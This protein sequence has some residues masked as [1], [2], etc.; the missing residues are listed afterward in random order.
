MATAHMYVFPWFNPLPN[1]KILDH[2]KLKAFADDKFKV[3]QMLKIL[4]NN[5][6]N[7]V[8]KEENAGYQDFLLFPQCFQKAIS[9][10]ALNIGIVWSPAL[11]HPDIKSRGSSGA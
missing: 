11:G 7:I 6:E 8:G 9:S 1:N 5:I 10:G 4:L 3:I 2:S